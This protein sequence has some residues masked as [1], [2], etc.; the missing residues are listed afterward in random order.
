MALVYADEAVAETPI[1][2]DPVIEPA[3]NYDVSP[4][5]ADLRNIL[6][7]FIITVSAGAVL[8]V[9]FRKEFQ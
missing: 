9:T 7:A 6:W 2:E 3:Y 4:E 8:V 1:V 5:T